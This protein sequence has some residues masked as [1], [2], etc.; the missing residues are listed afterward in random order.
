M[1]CTNSIIIIEHLIALR[2]YDQSRNAFLKPVNLAIFCKLN[3]CTMYNNLGIM[4]G[5][6]C[7]LFMQT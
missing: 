3:N 6:I 7:L 1:H 5:F 4:H 2:M